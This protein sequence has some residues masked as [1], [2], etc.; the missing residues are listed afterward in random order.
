[1]SARVITCLLILVFS[2]L[3]FAD[4]TIVGMDTTLVPDDNPAGYITLITHLQGCGCTR[5]SSM[6]YLEY[7]R[8]EIFLDAEITAKLNIRILDYDTNFDEVDSLL[9]IGESSF[10]PLIRLSDSIGFTT[11]EHAYEPVDSILQKRI[12]QLME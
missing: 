4:S 10:L 5:E 1:M 6:N 12:R 11:Y 3:T 2:K 7:F 9:N 8:N